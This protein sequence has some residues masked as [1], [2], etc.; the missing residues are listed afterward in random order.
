M[1]SKMSLFNREMI[2]QM[3]RSTGWV[4]IVYFLGLLLILPI[5]ILLMY[6]D[7]E[8]TYRYQ[9]FH[10]LFQYNYTFQLG[11]IVLVPVILAVFLFRFL[12]VKQAT[13][14][15]HSLPIKRERIFHYY[16]LTGMAFLIVPVVLISLIILLIHSTLDVS[17]MYTVTDVLYWTGTTILFTL[18]F[19]TASVFIAMMTGISAVQAVLSYIFLFFPVGIAILLFFNL[20]IL[21]Y[22]FP[23][24]YFLSKQMDQI[25]PLTYV[26]SLNT[27]TFQWTD[28]GI[29]F[30]A[31]VILYLLSLYFYKKR[32]L[33]SASEAIAFPKLRCVFKYGVTFCTMLLGGAYF[34]SVS[35]GNIGWTIFGY[36]V[37]AVLGYFTA[38]MV[39]QKSWRVFNNIKG[40]LVYSAVTALLVTGVGTLKIYEKRVPAVNDIKNVLLSENPS[41]NLDRNAT[42]QY[43]PQEPI[44]EKANIEAVRKLHQQILTNRNINQ[45]KKNERFVSYYFIYELKNGR[46]VIREYRVN[47]KLYSD[48]YKPIYESKEYKMN[49]API[50]KAKVNKIKTITIRGYGPYNKVVVLSNPTDVKEAVEALKVDKLTESYDDSMYFR[51]RNSSIEIDLGKDQIIGFEFLPTYQK[52]TEWLTEKNLLDQATV[53]ADD[54]SHVL[55]KKV[56]QT[57]SYDSE[58]MKREVEDSKDS[59]NVTDKRQIGELLSK[60]SVDMNHGYVAVFYYKAGNYTEIMFFDEAH[61]PD[62]VK[63]RLK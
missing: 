34:H 36:L 39:L 40:L 27:K 26:T 57:G 41:F 28:A 15:M 48:L 49:M 42:E 6:P 58:K 38:E 63:N 53:T 61:V 5:Q 47:E 19:Y 25:S 46:H 45:Q 4:S 22:G 32:N 43:F 33:E 10:T 21:L 12:H 18:L 9:P 17:S 59:L 51:S 3:A 23:S 13:D 62:F 35:S 14:L 30:I 29:Y 60:A 54:I 56:D 20:K 8:N 31:T 50:Y 1:Q 11:L 55:V 16:A 24:D 44:K 7:K 2:L 37:G 52:L